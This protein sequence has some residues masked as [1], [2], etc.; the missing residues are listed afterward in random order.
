M[1]QALRELSE[2]PQ[3]HAADIDAFLRSHTFPIVEGRTV[4]FVYVR[5]PDSVVSATGRFGHEPVTA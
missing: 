2:R 1:T 4:T 3:L 5:L